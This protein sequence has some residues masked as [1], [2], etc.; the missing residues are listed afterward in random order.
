MSDKIFVQNWDAPKKDDLTR[1]FTQ[2]AVGLVALSLIEE[3]P[4]QYGVVTIGDFWRFDL[5]DVKSKR[6][7]EDIKI[8]SLPDNLEPLMLTLVGIVE[9]N[10]STLRKI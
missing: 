9:R 3:Q 8:Y 2:M 10:F 4:F 7:T 6:I 1:E 5:L